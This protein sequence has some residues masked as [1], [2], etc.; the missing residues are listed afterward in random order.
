METN[1]AQEKIDAIAHRVGW[2]EGIVKAHRKELEDI[3]RLSYRF[4]K[5]AAPVSN[6]RDAI[7]KLQ[8]RTEGLSSGLNVCG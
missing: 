1:E 3:M 7:L 6:H 2:L 8:A 4:N 5:M